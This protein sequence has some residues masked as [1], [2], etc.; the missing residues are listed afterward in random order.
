MN[1]LQRLLIR[2][3]LDGALRAQADEIAVACAD[4]VYARLTRNSVVTTLNEA[5]G[6]VRARGAT[7]VQRHVAEVD[8]LAD[9]QRRQLRNMVADRLSDRFAAELVQQPVAHRRAA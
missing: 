1:R 2:M 4:A 3:G 8:R 7:I 5:R 9:D 6:Y